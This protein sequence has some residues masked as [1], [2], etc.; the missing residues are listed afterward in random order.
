M[1][2]NALV[3]EL[4]ERAFT[5][6]KQTEAMLESLI[7]IVCREAV[8]GFSIPGFCKFEIVDRKAR[9]G[10]NPRTREII[11]IPAGKSLKVKPLG[12]IKQGALAW[13][14]EADAEIDRNEAKATSESFLIECPHC[15]KQL[16]AD[17]GMSNMIATCPFCIKDLTVPD[18]NV[19]NADEDGSP[20]DYVLFDC[21]SCRQTIEARRSAAGTRMQCPTCNAAV[22]IPTSGDAIETRPEDNGKD[23]RD[24]LG[25]TIRIELP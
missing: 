7:H 5:T 1:N 20:N 8:N 11:D 23:D 13:I 25:T 12:R 14:P 18:F 9:K 2:K 21:S 10:R 19:C 24:L 22:V 16:E 17:A 6:H 15:S 4:S 3:S